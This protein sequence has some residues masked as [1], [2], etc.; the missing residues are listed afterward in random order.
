M[1]RNVTTSESVLTWEAPTSGG[2]V[3]TY[4]IKAVF[5]HSSGPLTAQAVVSTLTYDASTWVNLFGSDFTVQIRAR[6]SAGNSPWTE[7]VS[8]N[9]ARLTTHWNLNRPVLVG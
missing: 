8:S 9:P 5:N 6:N 3:D 1:P 2:T 7:A 4:T